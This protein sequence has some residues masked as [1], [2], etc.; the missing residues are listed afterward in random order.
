MTTYPK[1]IL[2]TIVAAIGAVVTV[3]GPG[4]MNLGDLGLQ[5]W[6]TILGAIASSGAIVWWT[7]NGPW[8]TYIKTVMAFAS[9]G[10]TSLIAAFADG[11][12][13]QGELL[14]ALSAA[15]VGSGLVFQTSGSGDT[16][17]P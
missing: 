5:D 1:A 8:H 13:T 3:L 15:I 10:L 17:A 12:V 2:T 14:I 6:L 9:A 11:T 4:N 7:Q 16:P